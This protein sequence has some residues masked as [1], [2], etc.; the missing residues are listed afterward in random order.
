MA[1]GIFRSTLLFVQLDS[2][3]QCSQTASMFTADSDPN[4]HVSTAQAWGFFV[5]SL[6]SIVVTVIMISLS[7]YNSH[8]VVQME[9]CLLKQASI[10]MPTKKSVIEYDEAMNIGV[11]TDKIKNE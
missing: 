4:E 2:S 7:V 3:W 11:R 10:N 1:N 6:I 9:R 5:L 8:S